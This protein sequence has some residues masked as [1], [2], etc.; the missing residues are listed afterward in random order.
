MRTLL[1]CRT[2]SS[3]SSRGDRPPFLRRRTI[4][5]LARQR[6]ATRTRAR[7]DPAA[8]IPCGFEWMCA[9]SQ[10]P[11]G[12]YLWLPLK[13]M[14][15]PLKGL[16]MSRFTSSASITFTQIRRFARHYLEMVIAMFAGMVVLGLPAEG[17]LQLA[18]SGSSE[19]RETA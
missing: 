12:G 11:P 6:R 15:P 13:L 10:I 5:R 3:G 18:G 17:L 1:G 16:N 2:V 7:L 14:T 4:R 8:R 19:L 9:T